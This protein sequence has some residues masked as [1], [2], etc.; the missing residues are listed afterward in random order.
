MTAAQNKYSDSQ[1]ND[2]VE[3]RINAYD[4]RHQLEDRIPQTI[5]VNRLQAIKALKEMESEVRKKHGEAVS[6]WKKANSMYADF[7]KKNPGSKAMNPPGSS[8]TLASGIED[9][10]SAIRAYGCVPGT[11][12]KIS[13][14]DWMSLFTSGG[15]A[16]GEMRRSRDMYV[17]TVSGATSSLNWINASATTG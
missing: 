1:V 6:A 13:R 3:A 2:I 12:L 14:S 15:R 11:T 8:P 16:I 5:T 10:R 9:I 7:V 4:S 17:A